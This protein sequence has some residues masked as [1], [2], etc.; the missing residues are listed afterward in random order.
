ML[1]GNRG[2]RSITNKAFDEPNVKVRNALAI[3]FAISLA[4]QFTAVAMEGVGK[5][6]DPH[7]RRYFHHRI[8]A[9]RGSV[10]TTAVAPGVPSVAKPAASLPV[11]NDSDGLSRDPEDCNKGCL[12]SSD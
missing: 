8:P 10:G 7:H 3:G 6:A 2:H 4:S 1:E 11:Q 9:D 5:P 12:D